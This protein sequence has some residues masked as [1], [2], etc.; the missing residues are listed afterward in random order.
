MAVGPAF[1][2]RVEDVLGERA[3]GQ[4]GGGLGLG[5]ELGEAGGVGVGEPAAGGGDRVGG[6]GPRGS[7]ARTALGSA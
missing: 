5:E 1:L 6:G 7:V 3:C 2:D 4:A